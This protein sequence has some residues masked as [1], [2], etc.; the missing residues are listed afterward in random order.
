MRFAQGETNHQTEPSQ[1][2]P[3]P[4]E[5]GAVSQ[6]AEDLALL[7]GCPVEVGYLQDTRE[8]LVVARPEPGHE[9]QVTL[10][11]PIALSLIDD[12]YATMKYD[13]LR[14]LRSRMSEKP[15]NG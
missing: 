2:T 6:L 10:R 4:G 13:L 1:T 11:V 14:E 3:W 5:V 12:R 8:V 9:V 7:L 15:A